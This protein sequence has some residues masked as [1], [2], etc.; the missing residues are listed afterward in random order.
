MDEIDLSSGNNTNNE[1]TNKSGLVFLIAIIAI[2]IFVVVIIF[3]LSGGTYLTY[4]N[5]MKIKNGMSYNEVVEILDG[6]KGELDTS[7]GGYGYYLSYY[8][9]TNASGS[10]CIVVCFEN[11]R[12]CAKSQYGLD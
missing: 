11:G 2:I 3:A 9:W 8:S 5:Y 7:G 6:H 1:P 12:V 4:D 10:A